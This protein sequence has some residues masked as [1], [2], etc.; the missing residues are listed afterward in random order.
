MAS[1]IPDMDRNMGRRVKAE[2]ESSPA[3]LE[4]KTN[5]GRGSLFW[6]GFFGLHETEPYSNQG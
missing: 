3:W 2:K 5:K 1:T 4:C 6:P